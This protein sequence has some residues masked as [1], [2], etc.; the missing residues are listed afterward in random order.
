MPVRPSVF[1]PYAWPLLHLVAHLTT[2][3]PSVEF[4]SVA[5]DVLARLGPALPCPHCARSF[6]V[7]AHQTQTL[8]QK[9]FYDMAV[10]G[11]LPLFVYQIHCMV[12]EKLHTQTYGVDVKYKPLISFEQVIIRSTVFRWS[13]CEIVQCVKNLALLFSMHLEEST[14]VVKVTNDPETSSCG[15]VTHIQQEPYAEYY[16]GFFGV[17]CAA[18]KMC[19]PEISGDLDHVKKTVADALGCANWQCAYFGVSK[20]LG[21][22]DHVSASFL[23]ARTKTLTPAE[24]SVLVQLFGSSNPVTKSLFPENP[25]AVAVRVAG[26]A[27]EAESAKA[28]TEFD[29]AR[30]A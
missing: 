10:T 13:F 16:A 4:L 6:A 27:E 9:S 21:F 26:F 7:F 14:S 19:I 23:K 30:P 25:F 20:A 15:I 22:S 5:V 2:E 29:K 17:L 12:S 8:A 18:L 11:A 28:Q 1:G 3:N 24:R